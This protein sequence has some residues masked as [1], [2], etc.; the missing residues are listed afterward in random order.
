MLPLWHQEVLIMMLGGMERVPSDISYDLNS[1]NGEQVHICSHIH[2]EADR[3]AHTVPPSAT[4]HTGA[5]LGGKKGTECTGPLCQEEL[6]S[7]QQ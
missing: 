7:D 6:M 2:R 3:Q 1:W 4:P 5:A